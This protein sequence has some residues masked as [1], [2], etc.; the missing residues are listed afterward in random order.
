MGQVKSKLPSNPERAVKY[1]QKQNSGR[2]DD[3]AAVCRSLEK[4]EKHLDRATF[5]KYFKYDEKTTDH[6]F[7]V[8]DNNGD[9]VLDR[10]EFVRGITMCSQGD[11]NEKMKFCF[12]LSDA[13]GE[14]RDKME[15]FD[16]HF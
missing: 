14:T 15:G 3:I 8:F 6:L 7:E 4:E 10:D 9:G 11:L 16:C 12:E 5:Q 1:L 13:S 2:L